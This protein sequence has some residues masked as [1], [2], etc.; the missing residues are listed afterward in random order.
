MT[1]PETLPSSP[2]SRPPKLLDRLMDA[3][4]TRG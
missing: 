4:R 1:A 3:L 2:V